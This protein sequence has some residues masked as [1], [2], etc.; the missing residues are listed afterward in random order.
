MNKIKE[1]DYITFCKIC[2]KPLIVIGK[3][4][5]HPDGEC[6]EEDGTKVLIQYRRKFE[7]FQKKYKAP[8]ENIKGLIKGYNNLIE[9]QD[10][11]NKS[12][13]GRIYK[14]LTKA[15]LKVIDKRT[16]SIKN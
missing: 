8:K 12:F 14:W 7:N 2:K 16:N 11:F 9:E 6:R 10:K 15:N 1:T 3:E 13:I 5:M 4:L